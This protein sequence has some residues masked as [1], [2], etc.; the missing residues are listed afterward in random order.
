MIGAM[1]TAVPWWYWPE[2]SAAAPNIEPGPSINVNSS[3]M[4]PK[5]LKDKQ[6]SGLPLRERVRQALTDILD[7]AGAPAAAKASACRSLMEFF[8]SD[9]PGAIAVPSPMAEMSV[10]EL[11]AA[12]A[13]HK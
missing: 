3:A 8:A 13:A 10:E 6:M 5:E 7:D 12:I 9:D 1:L 11:D 2:R 4:K